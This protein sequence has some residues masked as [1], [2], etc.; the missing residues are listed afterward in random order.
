MAD[1]CNVLFLCTANAARSQIAEA[2]VNR[3][4]AE[5]FRGWS[6]GSHPSGTVNPVATAMLERLGYDTAGLRSKGWEEF[7][8]PGAPRMDLVFTV[9]DD[10][11]GETCPV[12]PGDPV[13][14]HWSIPD[15]G[16]ATGTEAEIA[17][18]FDR[19]FAMLYR[20]IGLLACLPIGSLDGM[21]LKHAVDW[22]GE[23]D[24]ITE[25]G[26]A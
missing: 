21:R 10:A 8:G 5:R 23:T 16:R 14:A 11:A 24:E 12:W 1:R 4:H 19:V 22:I 9:C 17:V 7:V 2:I 20:R 6:A 26:S 18:A 13:R 25:P 3:H 15:P